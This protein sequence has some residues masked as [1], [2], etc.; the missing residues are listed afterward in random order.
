MEKKIILKV[1]EIGHNVQIKWKNF[2]YVSDTLY[3]TQ[4]VWGAKRLE[5]KLKLRK[6]F[7]KK[8]KRSY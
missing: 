1:I 3:G 8:I 7:L 4:Y 6:F 2:L 5:Q